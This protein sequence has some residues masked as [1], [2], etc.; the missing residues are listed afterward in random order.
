MIK[1]INKIGKVL[2]KRQGD[3]LEIKLLS[4]DNRSIDWARDPIEIDSEEQLAQFLQILGLMLY[5]SEQT[6]VR[7]HADNG[8]TVYINRV[9]ARGYYSPHELRLMLV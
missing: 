1:D 6:F 4:I 2:V 5:S 9:H 8:N 7:T 3:K